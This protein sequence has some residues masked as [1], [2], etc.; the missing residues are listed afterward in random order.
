MQDMETV[1]DT[2][3]ELCRAVGLGHVETT[4]PDE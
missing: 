4:E 2:S 1:V 3:L